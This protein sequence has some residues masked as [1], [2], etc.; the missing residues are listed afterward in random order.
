MTHPIDLDTLPVHVMHGGRDPLRRTHLE[1][2]LAENGITATWHRDVYYEDVSD[3]VSRKYYTKSRL[4]WWWRSRRGMPYRLL[5]RGDIAA[6]ISHIETYAE[7]ASGDTPW[8][9]ILEDDAI[10]EE[11]FREQFEEYFASTPDDADL[12]F[13]GCCFGMRIHDTQTGVHFYRRPHPATKC[14]DS[15]LIRDEAAR[16]L[17]QTM[18]RFA[19]PI[20]WELNYQLR[21]HDLKVYWLEPPL[22]TQ[23]SETGLFR[24]HRLG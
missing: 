15:Y 3:A 12:I 7:I 20:D 13:I 14:A 19:L 16:A 23:G 11:R 4:Q 18:V 10:L 2:Q 24:S 6:S 1:R 21:R 5:S 8:T 17:R 9:L 22:V